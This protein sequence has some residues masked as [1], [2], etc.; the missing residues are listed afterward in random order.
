MHP[1]RR[2]P[3]R[4]T[5]AFRLVVALCRARLE[6]MATAQG[7]PLR[8]IDLNLPLRTAN[9][10]V[11][12]R[13]GQIYDAAIKWNPRNG[14]AEDKAIHAV[15][16]P[17]ADRS[18]FD[19]V[20]RDFVSQ[21]D[22]SG[23]SCIQH[24]NKCPEKLVSDLIQTASVG[25]HVLF[26]R[27]DQSSLTT[28]VSIGIGTYGYHNLAIWHWS[29][30]HV[31]LTIGKFCSIAFGVEIFLDGL[32]DLSRA[33]HYPLLR[34]DNTIESLSK[35]R[36]R[37]NVVVGNDVWIGNG[38]TIMSGVHIGH[39]A[40]IGAK[41]VVAKDVEPYAV[42][43]GNPQRVVRRRFS[44]AQI[45]ELLQTA[46]WNW[47]SKDIYDHADVIMGPPE[48]LIKLGHLIKYHQATTQAEVKQDSHSKF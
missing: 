18:Y 15:G 20:A 2:V 48:E 12:P 38:A 11:A 1:S 46:W 47:P 14:T 39:G 41:A 28:T 40:V 42:V 43:V 17:L 37:G 22:I 27:P 5:V 4:W 33:S 24:P 32:H 3:D 35:S 19:E 29:E 16:W 21:H 34:E 25:N 44:D 10:R 36:S 31:N 26:V 13:I 30:S 7:P 23:P 8:R 9:I 6:W 45:E